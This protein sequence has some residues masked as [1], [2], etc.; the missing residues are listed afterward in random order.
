[1]SDFVKVVFQP[2]GRTVHAPKGS[3]VLDA[4]RE[5]G[6]D[7]HTPCGGRGTCGGCR[8]VFT[9]DAPEPTTEDREYLSEKELASGFRLACRAVVNDD[10]VVT[11]P[12][13]TLRKDSKFLLHGI[14]RDVK[15]DP[16]VLKVIFNVKAASLEDQRADADRL[17][18]A[19]AEKGCQ[20][21]ISDEAL[22]SLSLA[23]RSG[24]TVAAYISDDEVIEVRPEA[25]AGG[26]Y[27]VAFDVGTTTVVGMLLDLE[28]GEEKAVAARTNPQVSYGDD[29][30]S[31]ISFASEG[32][33]D[34]LQA[35]IIGCIN[36]I[37]ADVAAKADVST[38]SIYQVVICGNTTMGHL[39]LG[40][41]PSSVAQAP[42]VAVFRSAVKTSS[43]ALGIEVSPAGRVVFLP[44]VAGFI[45]GDTVGVMLAADYAHSDRLRLAVDI[46]TNGEIVIGN[47]KRLLA[48]S[49][50]A[51]PAFEG[52]R[53][54]HGMRAADGAIESV[55]VV[56]GRLTVETINSAPPVGICGTGLIDAVAALLDEGLIDPAGRLLSPDEVPHASEDLK[57]RLVENSIGP[58]FLLAGETD[59]AAREV[60][61]G[62]RDIR[63][64]QLAKGAI[65]AA[66]AILLKEYGATPDDLDEV[67]LAGAFG[68]YIKKE[69]ALRIG[70]LPAVPP[71][72]MSQI[73]NA[74]GTGSKLV[75][76]DSD[77][78]AE[79]ERLSV[80]TRYVELAGRA[81]FQTI[82][83]DSMMF[84]S[85]S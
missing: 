56:D 2:L 73:G 71:E 6:L 50:A 30:V 32:G 51:G 25:S 27:S 66:V 70:L 63:E 80:K 1:M 55:R 40:V 16:S 67:L 29:V 84:G 19:L 76:L 34:K 8:V 12:A 4:A 39:I 61:L 64:L 31:R 74:A 36:E 48:A 23:M 15:L 37:I 44:N 13:E 21:T 45:G 82:F 85:D 5:A 65:A 53:I 54:R 78:L 59:G 42:Y 79:A 20:V 68:S 33:L 9:A 11:V 83:A 46:G 14:T 49:A 22:P 38:A 26:V 10:C 17:T 41:D 62:Q 3:T 75:A 69:S 60:V 72:K 28:T 52:A 43:R 7:L 81:D 18:A 35:A 77:L 47:G 24:G 58:A 57:S